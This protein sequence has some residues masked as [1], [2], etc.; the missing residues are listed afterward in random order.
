MKRHKGQRGQGRQG[1]KDRRKR[2]NRFSKHSLI[3]QNFHISRIK[4]TLTK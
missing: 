2:L 4:P 3:S 1:G